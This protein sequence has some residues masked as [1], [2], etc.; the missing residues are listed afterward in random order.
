MR[1]GRPRQMMLQATTNEAA[2]HTSHH[3]RPAR[4]IGTR[5]TAT[6]TE[7]KDDTPL[8]HAKEERKVSLNDL[9]VRG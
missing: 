6:S 5:G 4:E 3:R 9:S 7:E 8:S 1:A 2:M